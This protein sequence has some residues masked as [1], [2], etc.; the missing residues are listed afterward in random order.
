M[1]KLIPLRISVKQLKLN[2]VDKL[3]YNI[4][5][6][7]KAD[8]GK[9]KEAKEYFTKA[10]ELVPKDSLSYFNRATVKINLGD[11][12]GTKLDF[13]LSENFQIIVNNLNKIGMN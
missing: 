9:F 13:A 6:V 1:N 11:I 8:S 12:I 4:K 7:K 10:I 3:F 2:E 5:G